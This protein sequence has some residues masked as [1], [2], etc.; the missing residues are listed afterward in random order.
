MTGKA[1]MLIGVCYRPPSAKEELDDGLW[2]IIEK[3]SKETMVMI[4]E[5]TSTITSTGRKWK[6]RGKKIG[7]L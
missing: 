7:S 2:E 6:V 4:G 3:D 1:I 5:G